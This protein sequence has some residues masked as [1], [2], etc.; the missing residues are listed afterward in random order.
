MP[1]KLALPLA[2]AGTSFVVGTAVLMSALDF[3]I[4]SVEVVGLGVLVSVF[5]TGAA[6]LTIRD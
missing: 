4:D 1:K 2:L 5:C 3:A 6:V